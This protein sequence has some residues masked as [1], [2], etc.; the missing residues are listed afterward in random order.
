M[1]METKHAKSKLLV[2]RLHHVQLSIPTGEEERARA[3]Y[4][5]VV[6]LR[7]IRKPE[8]LI[9]RGGL[10]FEMGDVELHLGAEPVVHPT[11]RHPGFEVEDLGSARALFESAGVK[12]QEEPVIPGRDRFSIL[13]PF[14]NRI[15]FLQKFSGV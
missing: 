13:D 7:E 9:S 10:W 4:G 6:G 8:S 11:K 2:K 12:I 14:G 15:E 3:F 5:D 1:A